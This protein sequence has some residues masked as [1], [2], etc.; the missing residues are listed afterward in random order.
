M[1]VPSCS[2]QLNVPDAFAGTRDSEK[3][4]FFDSVASL[5][6]SLPG[7]L[8]KY[9][10]RARTLLQRREEPLSSWKPS[11]PS[12]LGTSLVPID[13]AFCDYEERCALVACLPSPG[14]TPQ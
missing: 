2:A 11:P 14:S 4:A 10:A 5:D 7:G 12:E 3:H 13:A 6:A 1:Y 8:S 9:V